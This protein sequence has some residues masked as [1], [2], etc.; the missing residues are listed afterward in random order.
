MRRAYVTYR[1]EEEMLLNPTDVGRNV[2]LRND[3]VVRID[4][5]DQIHHCYYGTNL[6]TGKSTCIS[7]IQVKEYADEATPLTQE[8]NK[9]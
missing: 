4:R 5:F 2:R 3:E 7:Q 6:R 9:P 8:E 1:M